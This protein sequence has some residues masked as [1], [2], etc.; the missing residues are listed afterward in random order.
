MC[1]RAITG[2]NGRILPGCVEAIICKLADN[3]SKKFFHRNWRQNQHLGEGA[4][5]FWSS[6]G[7]MVPAYPAS[8][9]RL[10]I[11]FFGRKSS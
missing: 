4:H 3:P 1:D 2:L 11:A 7:M 8:T 10:S 5:Q 9:P 6:E